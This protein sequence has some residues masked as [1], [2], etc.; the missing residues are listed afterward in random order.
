MEE[1]FKINFLGFSCEFISTCV[2]TLMTRRKTSFREE[3]DWETEKERTSYMY[4]YFKYPP[5][6]H[7]HAHMHGD[8]MLKRNSLSAYHEQQSN[9][10]T[11]F[12]SENILKFTFIYMY[13]WLS[14]KQKHVQSHQLWYFWQGMSGAALAQ[15]QEGMWLDARF[16]KDKERIR[17]CCKELLMQHVICEKIKHLWTY[18]K[19]RNHFSAD[20]D[21]WFTFIYI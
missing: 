4:L 12:F 20:Q 17:K 3:K 9:V 16:N 5:N 18:F 21:V 6:T 11:F 1:N 8:M 7:T 10:V 15:T 2:V 13:K 14:L 19:N